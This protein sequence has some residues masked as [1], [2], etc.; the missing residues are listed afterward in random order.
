[1]LTYLLFTM[2]SENISTCCFHVFMLFLSLF[3]YHVYIIGGSKL[4]TMR[5]YIKIHT[6]VINDDEPFGIVCGNRFIGYIKL[7][8]S[9]HSSEKE[10]RLYLLCNASYYH[11]KFIKST[12]TEEEQDGNPPKKNVTYY[13]RVGNYWDITY[14]KNELPLTI[15]LPNERQEEIVRQ[16]CNI[17]EERSVCRCLLYGLSGCGKS[18]VSFFLNKRLLVDY[19]YE[20]VNFTDT[21]NPTVPGDYFDALYSRIMPTKTNPLVILIEEVDEIICAIH[22]DSVITNKNIP[23]QIKHKSDWNLFLD[24]FDREIYRNVIIIMTMNRSI[25]D[26]NAM[27]VSYFRKGRCDIVERFDVPVTAA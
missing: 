6:S 25:E 9:T 12:E 7:M 19:G 26:I 16:I 22:N 3:N 4:K 1:M 2:F 21:F 18:Y 20:T 8:N 14:T 13:I 24:K 15:K 5:K 11:T 27:D 23:T 17:Y 10:Q